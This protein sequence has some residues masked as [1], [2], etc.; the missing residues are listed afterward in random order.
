METERALAVGFSDLRGFS[1]Y[2]AE[3]GDREAFRVVSQFTDL[4][5][6]H[7]DQHGGRVLK[8]YG[9]GV[10]TSFDEAE[11]AVAC[12]ANMQRALRDFN[13]RNEETPI[14]AGIGLTWGP[15]IQ[16]EDDLF[17]HSVNFAKRLADVAKGGQIVVSSAICE[18]ITD[19]NRFCFREL[20]E[21]A[22]KG[23]GRH[24]LYELVWLDEVA[25]LCLNDDTLNVVLTE[26]D[27]LVL[28]FAKPLEERLQQIRQ[29]LDQPRD[30]EPATSTW[31]RERIAKRLEKSMPRWLESAQQW[32]SGMGIEHALDEVQV[33]YE[34]ER[35]SVI[36][37][38]GKNLVFPRG[39]FDPDQAMRF[40]ERLEALGRNKRSG[41]R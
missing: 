29:K 18:V 27:K 6:C 3:R 32:A 36:L 24:K 41:D 13:E 30:N 1:S 38:G 31:L 26:D 15:V 14:S 17:G 35:L 10:M 11:G 7:V 12:A 2:T 21:R 4:V 22:I 16:T 5:S 34:G 8:T 33:T 25:N 23:L 37:P 20:G 28:E 19:E 9:D 39:K 40:I